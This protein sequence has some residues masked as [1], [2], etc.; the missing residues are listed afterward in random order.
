VPLLLGLL[1]SP[2]NASRRPLELRLGGGLG[3]SAG[4]VLGGG[5]L[6]FEHGLVV[7]RWV[8]ERLSVGGRAMVVHDTFMFFDGVR[9]LVLEPQ[10]RWRLSEGRDSWLVG[11]GLGL[12]A[13]WDE[14]QFSLDISFAQPPVT[15]LPRGSVLDLGDLHPPLM[16]SVF[17]GHTHQWRGHARSYTLRIENRH[18][19]TWALLLGGTWGW[20]SKP[21]SRS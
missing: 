2:A 20:A 1:A 13:F 15:G 8:G 3:L 5:A 18:V 4:E 6:S 11:G 19:D 10:L 14:E 16:A 9:G 12:G 21:W 7:D 17:V